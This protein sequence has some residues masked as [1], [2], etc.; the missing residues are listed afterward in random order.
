MKFPADPMSRSGWAGID[1]VE[2]VSVN[3]AD[4]GCILCTMG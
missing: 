2:V 4:R 1:M 3:T